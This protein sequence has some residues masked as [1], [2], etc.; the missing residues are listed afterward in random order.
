MHV[1]P[2]IVVDG[3]GDADGAVRRAAY[4][5]RGLR[6]RP[7]LYDFGGPLEPGKDGA[8]EEIVMQAGKEPYRLGIEMALTTE[9]L[10]ARECWDV[11]RQAVDVFDQLDGPPGLEEK[12]SVRYRAG[13]GMG[14]LVAAGTEVH[15]EKTFGQALA[16]AKR[17]GD[18]LDGCPCADRFLYDRRENDDVPAVEEKRPEVYAVR[19]DFHL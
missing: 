3:C 9:K 11:L 17:L 12:F 13:V 10:L 1:R 2:L 7:G 8:P 6:R 15:I 16:R 18:I 19:C 14:G 5:A 4:H